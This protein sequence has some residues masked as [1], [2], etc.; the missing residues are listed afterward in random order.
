MQGHDDKDDTDAGQDAETRWQAQRTHAVVGLM[1]SATVQG[2]KFLEVL[3]GKGGA[4][5]S[6]A[7][8]R[9]GVQALNLDAFGVDRRGNPYEQT[10]TSTR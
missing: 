2:C 8:C 10:S 9:P 3:R 1:L 4:S 6:A 7:A 5:R